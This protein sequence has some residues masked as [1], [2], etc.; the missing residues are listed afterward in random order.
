MVH[1]GFKM[2]ME[3][4]NHS[5]VKKEYIREMKRLS[6]EGVKFDPNAG[7]PKDFNPCKSKQFT[8]S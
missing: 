6:K 2:K 7:V 3:D 1:T 5:P 4:T 8:W